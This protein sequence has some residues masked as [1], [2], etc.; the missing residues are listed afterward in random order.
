M[1]PDNITADHVRSAI[2]RLRAEGYP[3][4]HESTKHDL[5]FENERF[6]PKMVL[7]YANVFAN[8]SEFST[9]DFSGG[10]ESNEFLTSL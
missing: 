9:E 6:P 3:A 1:I 4:Q 2:A 10:P 8:G 5:A 7:S